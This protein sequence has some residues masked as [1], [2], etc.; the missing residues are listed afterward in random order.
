MQEDKQEPK[1]SAGQDFV[2]K[3]GPFGS[4]FFLGLFVAFLIYC[5]TSSPKDPLDGYEPAH[6]SSY[7]S[8]SEETMQELKTELDEN[9]FPKLDGIISDEIEDGKLTVSIEGDDYVESR[10]AILKY[11]DEDLFYFERS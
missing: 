2:K 9:V 8:Q 1:L 11:Y 10:D 6:S 5:F 7:Y 4:I 3:I